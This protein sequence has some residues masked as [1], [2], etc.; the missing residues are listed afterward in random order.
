VS[1][2]APVSLLERGRESEHNG[3]F[4]EAVD[5]YLLVPSVKDG[6]VANEYL[7]AQLRAAYLM[8]TNLNQFTRAR[9]ILEKLRMDYSDPA[10][11]AYLGQIY[12]RIA[13]Y[14]EARDRLE[15]AL[16]SSKG[17]IIRQTPEFKETLLYYTAYSLDK[18]YTFV[19]KDPGLLREAI[20][21]WNYFIEFAG[22]DNSEKEN[23]TFA[24]S[25]LEEL[26]QQDAKLN[27]DQSS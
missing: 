25:R 5:R 19:E 15:S 13:L 16:N 2:S 20:K 11:D 22:C 3:D 24:H 7:E 8:F 10:I 21:A 12:F 4:R 6:G 1:E 27:R 18:Q 17:S 14:P 9:S 26:G 23:C